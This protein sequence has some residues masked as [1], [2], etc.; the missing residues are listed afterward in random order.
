MKYLDVVNFEAYVAGC[1]RNSGVKVAWDEPNGTPRTDGKIMWLPTITSSTPAT[2]L[3]RMRYYVKHE[4]SHIQYSDFDALNRHRPTGLLALINNLLEDHRID[5]INDSLYDGDAIVSS[6]YWVLYA[7]DITKRM[8]STDTE[9]SKQQR[10]TIPLFVWDATLRTWI[11]SASEARDVMATFIT[12]EENLTRLNKLEKYTDELLVIRKQNDADVAE[13]VFDLAKRI[14]ADLYD[15]TPESYMD[16]P[17]PSKSSGEGSGKG[18]G[19][20]SDGKGSA[21]ATDSEEDRLVDIDKL[22]KA[23]GHEHKPSRTGFI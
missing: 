14:L 5:Y 10:L 11:G 3:T 21:D 9:L 20:D 19:D 23:I 6:N 2:W 4:T 22:M 8:G 17:K 12:D 15:A 7:E 1:A 16:A 18:E 13:R